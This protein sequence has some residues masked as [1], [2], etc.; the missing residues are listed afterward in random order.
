MN[1]W[2]DVSILHPYVG[3]TMAH[4]IKEAWGDEP[5]KYDENGRPLRPPNVQQ[6]R[7]LPARPLKAHT[8]K[9]QAFAQK[10]K[11]KRG[12]TEEVQSKEEERLDILSQIETATR[13]LMTKAMVRG[14]SGPLAQALKRSEETFAQRMSRKRGEGEIR[15]TLDGA[16][17]EHYIIDDTTYEEDTVQSMMYA[18]KYWGSSPV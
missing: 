10:M 12:A 6:V 16:K 7:G 1:K 4:H 2:K 11:E 18:A 8:S 3:P 14:S 15:T 5:L 13:A 17:A 9:L